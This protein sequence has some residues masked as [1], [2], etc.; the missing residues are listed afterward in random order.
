[1]SGQGSWGHTASVKGKEPWEVAASGGGAGYTTGTEVGERW[2][3]QGVQ[4]WGRGEVHN[5]WE[6]GWGG[7]HYGDGGGPIVVGGSKGGAHSSSERPEGA[8]SSPTN[9]RFDRLRPAVSASGPF[10]CLRPG[11]GC[12]GPTGVPLA[13]RTWFH[14]GAR[15][16]GLHLGLSRSPGPAPLG[17]ARL[18]DAPGRPRPEP[19]PP[20]VPASRGGLGAP[21]R[22]GR[23]ELAP[24]RMERLRLLERNHTAGEGGPGSPPRLLVSHQ[25]LKILHVVT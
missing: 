21:A 15:G 1:M 3:T 9:F 11:L 22:D 4:G 5:L 8:D 17:G 20:W 16:P 7:A 10:P 25:H 2:G 23:A 12:Q 13:T 14:S 6:R 19:R 18:A 24:G